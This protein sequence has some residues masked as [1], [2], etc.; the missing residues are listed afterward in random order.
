[1]PYDFQLSSTVLPSGRTAHYATL[2]GGNQPKFLIGN[3]TQYEG[4]YGLFNTTVDSSLCYR[5]ED[6]ANKGFWAH[7]IYPTVRAE[8]KG[9]YFCLNTYDRAQFTFTF[10]QFAAHVPNGD[11]VQFFRSLLALPNAG[12]YFPRLFLQ[13]NR[14]C[15][16]SDAG[17]VSQLENDTST[18]ALMN[19]LN[20][21]LSEIENQELI[22]S[23]RF[24]H[25][26][27]NDPAHRQLQVD[28]A[29]QLF[30]EN[31]KA[32][33]RRFN[34]NNV[35]A[36][37]CQVVCDVRHQGRATNDRIA[38][39]LNTG[40]NYDRAYTNLLT[41]GNT[42][43]AERINTVR[44]TINSLLA[45]GLFDKKWSTAKGDFVNM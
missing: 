39:A 1:M 24:V 25:W 20:P 28:T 13:N 23:A 36:K 3:R 18:Q 5:P 22:C 30:K 6:F 10:M 33:D 7:F 37:V 15:Y 14:I 41:I 31:M 2:I 27:Q 34:L 9:S 40:G 42:N 43:Y 12:A 32:Y 35:P 29:I 44:S 19:Y 8:S 17:T 4:N 21:G 45:A 38:L 26:A 11:F 16:R